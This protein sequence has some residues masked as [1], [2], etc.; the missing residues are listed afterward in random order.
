MYRASEAELMALRKCAHEN[1]RH[2][3]KDAEEKASG[4]IIITA[5]M[6]CCGCGTKTN[7]TLLCTLL[8]KLRMQG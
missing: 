3:L 7:M 6:C 4:N 8:H 2:A 1:H 5:D